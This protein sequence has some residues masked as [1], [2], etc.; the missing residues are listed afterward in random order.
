MYKSVLSLVLNT[1][2]QVE[3]SGLERCE[4]VFPAARA[5]K[6]AVYSFADELPGMTF[7]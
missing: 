3:N 1:I 5:Y 2:K 4:E 7:E 6:E